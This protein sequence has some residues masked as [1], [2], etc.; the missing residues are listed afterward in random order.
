MKEVR[1]KK[2]TH[3]KI[4]MKYPQKV[5]VIQAENILEVGGM[6]AGL[7][8]NEYGHFGGMMDM[9]TQIC[10]FTKNKKLYT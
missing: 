2:T 7:T 8:V 4:Y 9:F 1:C 10:K 6:G 3:G 5:N